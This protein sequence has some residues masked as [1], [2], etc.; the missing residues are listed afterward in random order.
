LNVRAFG[1]LISLS[2]GDTLNV[3]HFTVNV[4]KTNT[5]D[6]Q[7]CYK[8][9][10]TNILEKQKH[11]LL[12]RTPSQ[13]LCRNT[14]SRVHYSHA[15]TLHRNT[16][17]RVFHSHVRARGRM[18]GH[19]RLGTCSQTIRVL[20][21]VVPRMLLG[22]GRQIV[23]HAIVHLFTAQ[24]IESCNTPCLLLR[25]HPNNSR[26][27]MCVCRLCCL[28]VCVVVPFYNVTNATGGERKGV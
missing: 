5:A 15:Q 3:H 9:A 24:D 14:A 8:H 4:I 13:P 11:V 26:Q 22:V 19:E 6:S 2:T 12:H 23:P 18:G 27:H 28:Y 20:S 7:T 16:V 1:A 10:V 21:F 25:Q 17:S